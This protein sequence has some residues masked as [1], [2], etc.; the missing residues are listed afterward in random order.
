MIVRYQ[1]DPGSSRF[2]VQGFAT[3][4]LS[5]MAHNPT[6]GVRDFTG[7]IQFAPESLAEA[8]FGM[9]VQAASLEVL[10]SVKEQDRQEIVSR[11]RQEVLETATYPQIKF[12]ST[13][14]S[15]TRIADNWYRVQIQ[16]ELSLHGVTRPQ[17][18][19]A[20]LRILDNE[21]RLSGEFPLLLSAYRIKK[22]TALGGMITLKDEL[23]LSFDLAGQ[24]EEG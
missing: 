10:G 15:A 22:V 11:M 3:G 9:V 12:Q 16:G 2:T 17:A 1:L 20:Q 5:V 6:L 21:I 7:Q 13:S 4:M 18:V 24:K 14:I 19:D 23:K 8:A